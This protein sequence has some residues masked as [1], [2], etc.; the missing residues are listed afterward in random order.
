MKKMVGKQFRVYRSGFWM[1]MATW[2][3]SRMKT[4]DIQRSGYHFQ[5]NDYYSPLND[6]EF[7]DKNKDLWNRSADPLDIDWNPAG[8][9]EVAKEVSGYV[10]ELRD[11]PDKSPEGE[12][13]FC[14]QNNFW[15]NADAL[16]Q[17]GLVR[18]RKPKRYVEIGCGWSSLLLQRA[19][20]KNGETCNVTQIE[21]YPNAKIFSVLPREWQR[22]HCILQRAPM[23]PFENLSEGDILFYDGS[24]CSKTASDVN[25]F[26]FEI[27]PRIKPGVL[28]HLHDIFLPYDYPEEW[29]FERG[30]TWNEQYLL[31]AFLMNNQA[32]KIL[33]ANSWMYARE[34]SALNTLYQGV[35][36][37]YGCSFWLVKSDAIPSDRLRSS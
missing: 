29:M 35:Q 17:Y 15:N 24:H 6:L 22:H 33:I 13:A 8:Q 19:L 28:I 20:V 16:V 11:I 30:Q 7:L 12:T 27:L 5:R 14:W 31:Q 1:K 25:Y 4:I 34:K 37:S 9:L 23:E 2:I 32:Y 10:G 18:S 21:P 26:F 3:M 36:P